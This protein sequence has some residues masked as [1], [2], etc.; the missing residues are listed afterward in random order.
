MST[1]DS[2]I[3]NIEEMGRAVTARFGPD[4]WKKA[5]P[6]VRSVVDRSHFAHFHY[7][8]AR[9]VLR[10]RVARRHPS[11]GILGA[12]AD[13]SLNGTLLQIRAHLTA[14]FQSLHALPDTCAHMVYFCLGFD[15][16]DWKLEARDVNAHGTAAL[17]A[18]WGRGAKD[19]TGFASVPWVQLGL[20]H[21]LFTAL[22]SGS[23]WRHVRALV[24]TSKHRSIIRPSLSDSMRGPAEQRFTLNLEPFEYGDKS[25]HAIDAISLMVREHDRMQP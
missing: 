21:E 6:S 14:F 15:L 13:G 5:H 3:W 10:N 9:Q 12:I 2:P 24:N 17:L 18:D 16:Q 23:D 4:Q 11:A 8:Q 7:A 25:Y 1:T 20:V 22:S 19:L